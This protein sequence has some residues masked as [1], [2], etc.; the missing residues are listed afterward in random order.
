MATF[1]ILYRNGERDH[2]QAFTFRFQAKEADV[3]KFFKSEN[4]E[5][6]EI[7]VRASEV[8]SVVPYSPMAEAPIVSE[9]QS[10]VSVLT[11]RVDALENNLANNLT[12]I[13][14]QAVNQAVDA[15]F[16]KRGL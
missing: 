8:A 3:I 12:N 1:R 14:T 16:T 6:E 15:A 10:Q 13:V 5:N 2:V 7:F 11:S 9:L 4:V